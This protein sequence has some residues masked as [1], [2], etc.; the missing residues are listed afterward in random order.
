MPVSA[1]VSGGFTCQSVPVFQEVSHASKCLCFRRFH[2]PVSA[3][4]SGG[5]TK[6]FVTIMRNNI[7]LALCPAESQQS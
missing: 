2:M 1:C 5:I 4:V 6:A 3:C 7:L